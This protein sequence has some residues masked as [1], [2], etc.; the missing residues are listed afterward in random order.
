M[1]HPC[2]TR[3]ET[4]LF[5]QE[6]P[7]KFEQDETVLYRLMLAKI[8]SIILAAG[9]HQSTADSTQRLLDVLDE[10]VQPAC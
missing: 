1:F 7:M 3:R 5:F 9:M 4:P 8:R 2:A 10:S 6:V